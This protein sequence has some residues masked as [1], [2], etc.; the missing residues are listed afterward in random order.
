M[1]AGNNTFLTLVPSNAIVGKTYARFR[2]SSVGGL[3]YFGIA[4]DGEVEDYEITII[5]DVDVNLKVFL[6][7][8]FIGPNMTTNLNS[9]G[10]IPL[11]QPY[12]SES[13]C[14]LVLHWN[15][16]CFGDSE[17]RYYRLGFSGIP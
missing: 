8:P 4:P 13:N 15:R 2:F 5:G 11:Y 16:K 3:A 12:N 1:I 14:S 9:L 6:E 7:G 17:L 10:V